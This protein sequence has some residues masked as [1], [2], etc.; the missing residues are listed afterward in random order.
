MNKKLQ[1]FILLFTF[2]VQCPIMVAKDIESVEIVLNQRTKPKQNGNPGPLKAPARRVVVPI[3]AF[4]NESNRCI[5]VSSTSGESAYYYVYD[6]D[7]R[8]V[9]SGFVSFSEDGY[10]TINLGM[11]LDGEYT[12]IVILDGVSYEGAFYLL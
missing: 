11:L 8:E 4:L 10:A 6:E 5:S 2:I 1:C 3:N 7:E 9:N 12:I